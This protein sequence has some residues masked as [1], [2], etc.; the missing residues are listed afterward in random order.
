M[1]H[2][3]GWPPEECA[4]TRTEL[5]A[6]GI[7]LAFTADPTIAAGLK[8]VA[9]GNVI[10][11]TLAGLLVGRADFEARLLRLLEGSS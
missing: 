6:A 8:V 7:T 9:D 5:A 1:V 3:T 10:D 4:A 2:A 11:G